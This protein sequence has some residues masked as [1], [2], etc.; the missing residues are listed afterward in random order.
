[1]A[2]GNKRIDE[3]TGTALKGHEWDGIQELDTPMPRWWLWTL[4]ATI[5]W[6]LIY[7]VLYPAWPLVES[8]TQG[9]LGCSSRGQREAEFAAQEKGRA[10][11]RHA[12]AELPA[13]KLPQHPVLMQ[14]AVEGGRSAF[15]VYCVQCHGSVG[16]P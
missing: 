14:A 16:H 15:K 4:Y 2:D 3:A 12:I 13:E 10:A 11:V 5:F 8:A 7:V 6:S 1:M 9:I